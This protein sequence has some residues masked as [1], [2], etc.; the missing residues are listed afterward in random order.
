MAGAL[1]RLIKELEDELHRAHDSPSND[2]HREHER[3]NADPS[4]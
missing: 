1:E 3:D 4:T 2:D